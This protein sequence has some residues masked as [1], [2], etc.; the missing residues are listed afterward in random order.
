MKYAKILFLLAVLSPTLFAN[1]YPIWKPE[2]PT[3]EQ[4]YDWIKTTSG[5]WLKGDLITLYKDEIEFDSDEFGIQLI[6][7][8]DVSE[9]YSKGEQSIRLA[10]GTILNGSLIIKNDE[11]TIKQGDEVTTYNNNQLLS[12]AS[13][14]S[15]ELDYW[16]GEIN[17][18]TNFRRGNSEQSDFTIS[19]EAQRR[20]S[21]GRFKADF[22]SNFSERVSQDTGKNEETANDQLLTST[23]DW[24]FSPKLFIRLA[25]YEYF[26]DEFGNIDHR[27]TLGVGIGY[28]ITDNSNYSWEV[29]AGPSYQ[30]TQF[31]SV[32]ENDNDTESSAVINLG[33]TFEWD[34]TKDTEFSADYQLQLVS[35]EAGEILHRLKSGLEIDLLGDFE[36]DLTF[37]LDRIENPKST[38]IITPEKNDYRFVVSLGYEF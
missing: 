9:F 2:A 7:I 5:E 23:F 31:I 22:I 8:S 13:S 33:T 4:K 37:Y 15:N 20:T 35:E 32:S 12:I 18:G 6:D 16:D 10:D 24:F 34:I 21:T 25:D 26:A 1:N 36:L 29:N 3:L 38:G 17:L 30:K 11:F 27:H 14:G 28:E 19:A